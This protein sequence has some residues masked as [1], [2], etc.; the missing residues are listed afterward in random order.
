MKLNL[1]KSYYNL[2]NYKKYNKNTLYLFILLLFIFLISILIILYLRNYSN[3][4]S[5]IENY[6]CKKTIPKLI[7][8]TWK[9]NDIPKK[10]H[11]DIESLIVLNPTF[12]YMYFNDEDIEFFLK[13]NYNDKYYKT[14]INLPLKI[15]KIDYFRYVAIYHFGGFY[16]DLDITSLYPLDELLKYECI[17]PV[18]NYLSKNLCKLD[19][20]KNICK[21]NMNFILGQYA[22]ASI[23]KHP[24][25]KK[26]IDNI[27]NNIK[28]IIDK[29]EIMNNR[30]IKEIEKN[31]YIY[32]TTG[33]DYVTN[34]YINYL[35][36]YKEYK[37]HIHILHY[38]KK[39]YFGKYA[40]HNHYGTW[41]SET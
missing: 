23:P 13:E 41:K 15:Q 25:M 31:Y 14:Y 12:T 35:K 22:F 5:K 19:R 37:K 34:N 9:D 36:N 28:N 18:D 38:I 33:P 8:Q 17:F 32:E 20:Y 26:L 4:N 29:Y 11:K 40:K 39:Q 30:K 7:I 1:K 21:E 6:T 3:L 24:F 2:M 27:D 10:Y 16:F